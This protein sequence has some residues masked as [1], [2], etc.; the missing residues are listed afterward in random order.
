MKTVYIASSYT[1]GNCN[2]NVRQP[3]LIAEKLVEMGYLP[4]CPLL[5][6]FWDFL[7]PHPYDYWMKLDEGWLKKCDILLRLPGESEGA[8]HEVRLAK[9]NYIPVVFGMESFMIQHAEHKL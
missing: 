7:S 2:D 3:L 9:L 8:D 1:K 6:H 4:F 5:T